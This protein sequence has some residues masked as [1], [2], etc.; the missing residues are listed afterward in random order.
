[1][2]TEAIEDQRREIYAIAEAIAPTWERRRAEIEAVW[3]R[4]RVDA[5]RALPAAR[6]HGAGARRGRRRHRLRCGRAARRARPADL[7]RLLAGDARRRAAARGA[8]RGV[9]NVDYRLIDAERI[10]LPDDSI[11]AVLCRFGYM[12]MSEP[13][14]ALAETR[15]VLR[16]GGREPGGVGSAGAKPVLHPHRDRPYP[17][18][19]PAA[20]RAVGPRR[21]SG[22]ASAEGT[23]VL[24]ER[25]GFSSVRTE[26][27]P[28]L[29]ELAGVDEYLDLVAGHGRAARLGAARALRR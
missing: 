20:A 12:P 22:L 29:F 23:T 28:V 26:E 14:T 16:P 6:R 5:A 4:P 9:E 3:P 21:P 2:T 11:D 18:R 13:A 10:D 27:V 19:T 25:A 17:A 1:M 15:R 8:E 24:L 7:H